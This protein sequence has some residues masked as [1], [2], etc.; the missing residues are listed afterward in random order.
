[1][2]RKYFRFYEA[3]GGDNP[4]TTVTETPAA[5]V[6]AVEAAPETTVHVAH[7][8]T[9]VPHAALNES[10]A[11]LNTSIAS[12]NTGINDL[13]EDLRKTKEAVEPVATEPVEAAGSTAEEIAPEIVEPPKERY[14]RRNGRRVKR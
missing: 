13:R 11:L 1:M 14:I 2:L 12:L 4:L 8:A 6:H 5:V 10:I 7:Q 3:D 9:E